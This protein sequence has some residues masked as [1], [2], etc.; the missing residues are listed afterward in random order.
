MIPERRSGQWGRYKMRMY[1]KRAADKI[2]EGYL[3]EMFGELRWMYQ[4]IRKYRIW[5]LFYVA[6]GILG[7][8]M[9]LGVSVISKYLIDV[10]V[11]GRVS[12]LLI[13]AAA[14]TGL[15]VGN[16]AVSAIKMKPYSY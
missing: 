13:P 10:V 6:A 16:I 5:I 7:I 14:M 8:G 15:A 1:L 12:E 11:T 3:K 2:R 9:S 4:Y